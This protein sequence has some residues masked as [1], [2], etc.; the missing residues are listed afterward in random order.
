MKI[1]T[2]V[3]RFLWEILRELSFFIW[4]IMQDKRRKEKREKGIT[5]KRRKEK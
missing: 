1:S 4:K 2:N 5:E 3:R